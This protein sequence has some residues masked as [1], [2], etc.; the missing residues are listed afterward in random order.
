VTGFW[1]EH[2]PTNKVM[3][4]NH[5]IFFM[6]CSIFSAKNKNDSL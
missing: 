2:A 6:L 4:N 1:V 5:K 3:H